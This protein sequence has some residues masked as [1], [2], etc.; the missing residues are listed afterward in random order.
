MTEKT[1][2]ALHG[3]GHAA[4]TWDKLKKHLPCKTLTLPGHAPNDT[5]PLLPTIEDMA[6]WVSTQL[7]GRPPRSVILI[8][9]SMGALVALE[10]AQHPAI[11]SLVLLG[12]AAKMP[13]HEN[14]LKL[15]QENPSAA[16]DMT[17]KWGV[18]SVHPKAAEIRADLKAHMLSVPEKA[19]FADLSACNSYTNGEAA[20]QKITKPV[21]LVSC[22]GDKMVKSSAAEALAALIPGATFHALPGD[23][24]MIMAEN[25]EEIAGLIK[26]LM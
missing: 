10:T 12:G 6:A 5:S 22:T 3:A 21:L 26:P 13:V 1:I 24:H 17:L 11:A 4:A 23:G 18:S 9:H 16:G 2:I 25:P 15:A 20:A 14:L 7:S 19:L 8:G